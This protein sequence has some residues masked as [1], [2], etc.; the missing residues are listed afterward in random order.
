MK[1]L[2]RHF[3]PRDSQQRLFAQLNELSKDLYGHLGGHR[4]TPP[5][6]VFEDGDG[7]VTF[8]MDYQPGFWARLTSAA[9]SSSQALY[10]WVRV[11]DDSTGHGWTTTGPPNS[12]T[13]TAFEANGNASIA[14]PLAPTGLAVSGVSGGTLTLGQ[15]YYWV[16]TATFT[17]TATGASGLQGPISSEVTFTPS[18]SQQTAGLSWTA[19]AAATGYTLTGYTIWRGT[20]A[21]NETVEVGTTLAGTTTFNDTGGAGSA[22]SPIQGGTA[23]PVVWLTPLDVYGFYQFSLPAQQA[24]SGSLTLLDKTGATVDAACTSLKADTDGVLTFTHL[25]ANSDQFVFTDAGVSQRGV[26]NTG[27]Q[28]FAGAKTFQTGGATTAITVKDAGTPTGSLSIVPQNSVT[29]G[30]TGPALSGSGLSQLVFD[31]SATRIIAWDTGGTSKFSVK[32]GASIK[33]GVSGTFTNASITVSGG[34]VTTASS[35]AGGGVNLQTGTSYTF[36]SGDLGKLVSFTN[37]AAMTATLPSAAGVGFGANWYVFVQNRGAGALTVTPAFNQIDGAAS[38]SVPAGK[39]AV[40]FCD[41]SNYYTMRG[42][43]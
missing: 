2:P 26:V 17:N 34:I 22:Q 3:D 14:V 10:S 24:S 11:I 6:N 42:G 25:A 39:G 27:S 29:T 1:R 4:A 38:L 9:V 23:G 43:T 5:L 41:S 30:V 37:A 35:G 8:W 13:S 20:A 40:I 21:G 18:G 32:S 31:N 19:P 7:N 28:T 36:V 12:G 33:D 15:A 16:V